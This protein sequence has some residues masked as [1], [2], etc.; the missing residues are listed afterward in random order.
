MA[1]NDLYLSIYVTTLEIICYDD[2]RHLRRYCR[3]PN[4]QCI[5]AE[6]KKLGSMEIVVDRMHMKG[7]IDKWCKKHCDPSTIPALDKVM[8]ESRISNLVIIIVTTYLNYLT[9]A[10]RL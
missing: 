4:H 8:S 2:A 5:S 6:S 3:N 9:I 1:I 7:H 10:G